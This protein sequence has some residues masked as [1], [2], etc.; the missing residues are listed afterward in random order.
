LSIPGKPEPKA[1]PRARGRVHQPISRFEKTVELLAD[2]HRGRFSGPVRVRIDFFIRDGRRGDIDNLQKSTLDGL[3]K[4]EV[5][6]DDRDV[7]EVT[8]RIFDKAKRD[9]TLIEVCCA[10]GDFIPREAGEPTLRGAAPP[11][12]P[13]AEPI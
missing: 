6:R 11:E 1:R 8:A 5:W 12:S 10:E 7:I 13:S 2:R 3:T 4:A 9:Q